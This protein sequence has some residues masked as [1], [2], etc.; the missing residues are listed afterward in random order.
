ML[1]KEIMKAYEHKIRQQVESKIMQAAHQ[2]E[3]QV[4]QKI[5]DMEDMSSSELDKL[6]DKRLKLMKKDHNRKKR[7]QAKGRGGYEQIEER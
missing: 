2:V 5:K 6:R 4:E 7:W 3:R 1:Q